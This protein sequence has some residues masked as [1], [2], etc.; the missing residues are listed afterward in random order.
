MT[1]G[2]ARVGT[3]SRAIACASVSGMFWRSYGS[4][5]GWMLAAGA[6]AGA[7]FLLVVFG[8]LV[9][10]DRGEESV[11]VVLPFY[12]GFFGA[13]TATAASVLYGVSLSLWTLRAHRSVASRAWLGA[14]SAAVGALGFWLVY[15]YALSGPYGL[16]VWG[17]IGAAAA[18]LA[19]IT[20]GPLT[21]RAAHR[22]D[23][24]EDSRPLTAP[25]TVAQ[26]G[27][28]ADGWD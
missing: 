10:V 12:G 13:L 16:P 3:S 2:R 20:A 5:I 6:V 1:A 15:G 9:P 11:I 14:A 17:A 19:V 8:L 25:G 21:A 26:G 27:G 23:R 18:A 4:V 24:R 22:A 28:P 7:A